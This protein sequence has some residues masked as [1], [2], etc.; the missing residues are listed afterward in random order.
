MISRSP[1]EARCKQCGD[2]QIGPGSFRDVPARC[3]RRKCFDSLHFM[4]CPVDEV[5]FGSQNTWL[6]QRSCGRSP[7][8]PTD[9]SYLM[10]QTEIASLGLH[11]SRHTIDLDS[12]YYTPELC[13]RVR[14]FDKT[15]TTLSCSSQ[16]IPIHSGRR[17]SRSDAESVTSR[18]PCVRPYRK[19]AG[20]ECK[21]T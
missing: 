5:D 20:D 18:D 9:I 12:K 4:L 8:D 2:H 15:S 6:P 3:H 19:P 13:D 10:I 1:D 11:G 17:I 21:G 16:E 7:G 14:A